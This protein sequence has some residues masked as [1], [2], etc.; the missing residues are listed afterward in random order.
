MLWTYFIT[1]KEKKIPPPTISP[2]KHE[3][4]VSM[5]NEYNYTT[6]LSLNRYICFHELKDTFT[7]QRNLFPIHIFVN[8][9]YIEFNMVFATPEIITKAKNRCI[10]FL[11]LFVNHGSVFGE[12]VVFFF[13]E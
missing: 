2:P 11:L 5:V 1:K 9:K 12:N 8:S 13:T 10:F 3:S 4:K 6:C 7:N